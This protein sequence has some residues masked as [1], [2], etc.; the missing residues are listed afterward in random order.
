MK[1]D[2]NGSFIRFGRQARH[3]AQAVQYAALDPD[4]QQRQRVRRRSRQQPNS[5]SQQRSGPARHLRH[6]GSP[7]AAVHHPGPAPV[8]LQL[9][10]QPDNNNS[11][12]AAVTG[13]IYKMELDGTVMGKFGEAGKQ[14]KE[15]STVHCHGLRDRRTTSSSAKSPVGVCKRFTL[16]SQGPP[17]QRRSKRKLREAA[18]QY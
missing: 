7:W 13:E 12:Q 18:Q 11:I 6:V 8:S 1:Y 10:F 16:K 14:L 4:G 3:R 5:G 2:K 17:R 9:Q 15:F